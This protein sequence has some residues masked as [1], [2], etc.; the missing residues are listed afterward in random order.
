MPAKLGRKPPTMPPKKAAHRAETSSNGWS[1]YTALLFALA[2]VVACWT[3]SSGEGSRTRPAPDSHVQIVPNGGSMEDVAL[4]L[5]LNSDDWPRLLHIAF[6]DAT[7]IS[8]WT[9]NGNAILW[10]GRDG[11]TGGRMTA[12]S[13]AKKAATTGGVLYAVFDHFIFVWPKEPIGT[14]RRIGIGGGRAI[15]LRTLSHS[16]RV[17]VAD[18]VLS[19]AECTAIQRLAAAR[20]E[21]SSTF[22]QGGKR[23]VSTAGGDDTR[24]SWNAWL[25]APGATVE[26]GSDEALLA[27]VQRRVAAMV[28]LHPAVAEAM[29][30]RGWGFG[31]W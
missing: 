24:T 14:V 3:L 29:Q 4:T 11:R 23:V 6:P 10:T 31:A 8:L 13:A 21:P 7:R 12:A 2:A 20:L 5:D 15:E 17:L 9:Y 28:R 1:R 26:S 27:E 19:E 22:V 30:A 18:S 16:P 25:E